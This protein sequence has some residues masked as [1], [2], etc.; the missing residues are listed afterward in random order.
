MQRLDDYYQNQLLAGLNETIENPDNTSKSTT[1][2]N[3][4]TRNQ[5]F[6][7]SNLERGHRAVGVLNTIES[8]S[9]FLEGCADDGKRCCG[10]AKASTTR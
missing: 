5:S 2:L 1:V 9:E 4:I 7:P 3:P 6:D 10:S 8:L